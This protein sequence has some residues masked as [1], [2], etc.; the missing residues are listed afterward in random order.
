MQDDNMDAGSLRSPC[1]L[2]TFEQSIPLYCHQCMLSAVASNTGAPEVLFGEN[3][4]EREGI[5]KAEAERILCIAQSLPVSADHSYFDKITG[6]THVY[7]R[8]N[9]QLFQGYLTGKDF[10]WLGRMVSDITAV[11]WKRW[12]SDDQPNPTI[13]EI[14]LLVQIRQAYVGAVIQYNYDLCQFV[15]RADQIMLQLGNRDKVLARLP[16]ILT[17]VSIADLGE[18]TKCPICHEIYG[19]VEGKKDMAGELPIC[20]PCSHFLGRDC[21]ETWI[22]QA[23]DPLRICTLC[24][25]SFG[26]AGHQPPS[27]PEDAQSIFSLLLAAGLVPNDSPAIGMD[28]IEACLVALHPH[29]GITPWFIRLLQGD[30]SISKV[31]GHHHKFRHI[32]GWS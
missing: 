25:K 27:K 21:L 10:I 11:I 23:P 13:E 20:L 3:F 18:D 26:I 22:G 12:E 30:G 1:Q 16:E 32:L 24:N 17:P 2:A 9:I 15:A 31:A 8:T 14:T 4:P 29:E 7:E 5:R 6:R 19:E 28:P